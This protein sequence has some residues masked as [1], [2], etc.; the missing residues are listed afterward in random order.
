MI[1]LGCLS[2][3]L[4]CLEVESGQWGKQGRGQLPIRRQ[5]CDCGA[6]QREHRAV[7][8][9]FISINTRHIYR[10]DCL[11]DPFHNKHDEEQS[12]KIINEIL[13]SY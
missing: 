3:V 9:C 8:V 4:V 6:V 5:R 2:Y 12:C 7:D 10:Q 1:T 11:G 13:T